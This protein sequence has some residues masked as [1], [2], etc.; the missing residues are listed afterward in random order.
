MA[1]NDLKFTQGITNSCRSVT[2]L[3]PM[4]SVWSAP[5]HRRDSI[6]SADY[7]VD[8]FFLILRVSRTKIENLKCQIG[9]DIILLS[10]RKIVT[11]L[12][13]ILNILGKN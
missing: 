7:F 3:T 8:N 11:S 12:I 5:P 9:G 13:Q 10:F 1:T 2:G 4:S 6:Q